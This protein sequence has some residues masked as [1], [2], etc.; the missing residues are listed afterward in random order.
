MNRSWTNFKVKRKRRMRLIV[1]WFALPLTIISGS[2]VFWTRFERWFP[3]IIFSSAQHV[4]DR[5][6]RLLFDRIVTSTRNTMSSMRRTSINQSWRREHQIVV[7]STELSYRNG[8]TFN[9]INNEI[10]MGLSM[11]QNDTIDVNESTLTRKLSS[12]NFPFIMSMN[13]ILCEAEEWF[14][15]DPSNRSTSEK[16]PIMWRKMNSKAVWYDLIWSQWVSPR[17]TSFFE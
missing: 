15:V 7:T 12:S 3:L 8:K 5:S 16:R 14:N 4:N 10:R 11:M 9:S 13:Q 1:V 6:N 2:K 17:R